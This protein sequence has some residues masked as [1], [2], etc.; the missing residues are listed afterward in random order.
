MG[1]TYHDKWWVFYLQ[2]LT[3]GGRKTPYPSHGEGVMYHNTIFC[4]P[5]PVCMD[6]S[7]RVLT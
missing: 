5:A 4:F 2:N 7:W 6:E 1:L 3:L